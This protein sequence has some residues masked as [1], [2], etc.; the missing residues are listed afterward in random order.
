MKVEVWFLK[1]GILEEMET[2]SCEVGC[3]GSKI[4]DIFTLELF[5]GPLE[6]VRHAVKS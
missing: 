1:R 3:V 5:I 4:S 2:F 6:K